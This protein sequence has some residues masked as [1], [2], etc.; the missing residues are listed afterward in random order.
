[1]RD[2]TKQHHEHCFRQY[3]QPGKCELQCGKLSAYRL[4]QKNY[5]SKNR[6]HLKL[7]FH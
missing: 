3:Q 6:I 5:F 4:G 1:M 2:A 7:P